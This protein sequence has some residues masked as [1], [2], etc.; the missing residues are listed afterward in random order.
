[1]RP[2]PF[3]RGIE[4][5]VDAVADRGLAF[6][7]ASTF[8]SRNPARPERRRLNQRPS[9]RP[10]PFGRGITHPL[11]GRRADHA[12]PSM[13]PRPFGRGIL[14]R[15]RAPYARLAPSMRPRPFGRGIRGA[16]ADLHDDRRPSMRPRPFGRGIALAPRSLLLGLTAFNEASTFRS[17]N[18]RA[19]GPSALRPSRLQ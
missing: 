6:N 19:A 2:R 15:G 17:R 14:L 7:E 3:G 9:M 18:R 16:R 5:A 10:R 8:R 13:R 1:M 4:Q 12:L 11:G